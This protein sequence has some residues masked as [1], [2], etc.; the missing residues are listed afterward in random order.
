MII[1]PPLFAVKPAYEYAGSCGRRLCYDY[2]MIK[3][4]KKNKWAID[5]AL[6][7]PIPSI[8]IRV[9]STEKEEIENIPLQHTVQ[10]ADHES[11]KDRQQ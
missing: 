6:H 11:E 4:D 9:T 2:D 5:L 1:D 7:I 8:S 3:I 10:E